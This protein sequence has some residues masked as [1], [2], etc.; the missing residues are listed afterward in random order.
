[1]ANHNFQRDE[2][3]SLA[4]SY[5]SDLFF[6]YEPACS[7]ESHEDDNL[8]DLIEVAVQFRDM[9]QGAF[10]VNVTASELVNDFLNRL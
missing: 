5:L 10:G 8:N 4:N 7:A 9:L 6:N 1:M 3:F 2:N